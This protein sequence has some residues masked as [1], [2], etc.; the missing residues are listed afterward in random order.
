MSDLFDTAGRMNPQPLA[1]A[2]RP[3]TLDDIIGQEAVVAP[4]SILRR[5][6]AAGRLGSI[7]LYGPPGLG[8][9]SML[10]GGRYPEA[11]MVRDVALE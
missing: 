1:A 2:L 6:I 8:K 10:A 4:G 9:T 11:D 5:R 7:I 3:A